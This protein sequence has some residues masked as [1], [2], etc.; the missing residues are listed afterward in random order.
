M[1]HR[2]LLD[3]DVYYPNDIDAVAFESQLKIFS[4]NFNVL[5]VQDAGRLIKD[6]NLPPRSICL[7]FDD[8][9]K[10]NYTVALPLLTKYGLKG[11]FFIAS[12]FLNGG[13]MW[14]D[15]ITEIIRHT[16]KYSLEL[17]DLG[18][19]KYVM[20]SE[21]EKLDTT[22]GI[23]T[24]IKYFPMDRRISII[25]Q[26]KERLGTIDNIEMMMSENDVI[27]MHKS[28]MEIGGHTVNH[29]ILSNLSSDETLIE[30]EDNKKNLEK[31]LGISLNTF[32]YPNGK[33]IR[34]Y[35]LKDI[36]ILKELGYVSAVS[37]AWG[38]CDSKTDTLQ[39]PRVSFMK[40]NLLGLSA[41]MFR[42][43]RD[44]RPELVLNPACS[45]D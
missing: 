15:M 6:G 36:K 25:E 41:R 18:L 19:E 4:S 42:A 44:I 23:I 35:G 37:T 26:L 22:R 29:P 38:F 20:R 9:Y 14:N 34:D 30:I 45:V 16:S 40:T 24:N 12:G 8:G 28:G 1:Y 39:M 13:V 43:Y 2:V 17:S 7:T 27:K 3:Q 33:P 11:T 10:D 32:A 5:T 31:L 21:K